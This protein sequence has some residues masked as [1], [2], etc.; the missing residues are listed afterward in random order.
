[1]PDRI[2]EWELKG[3]LILIFMFVVHRRVDDYFQFY[4]VLIYMSLREILF[5]LYFQ[6]NNLFLFWRLIDISYFNYSYPYNFNFPFQL[7]LELFSD[8]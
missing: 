5:W 8:I 4:V 7:Q 6:G 3:K 2:V 1:M